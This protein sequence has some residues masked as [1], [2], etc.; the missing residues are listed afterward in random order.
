MTV[1]G[2]MEHGDLPASPGLAAGV[3]CSVLHQAPPVL[4]RKKALQLLGNPSSW[5]SEVGSNDEDWPCQL[6][7]KK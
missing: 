6:I 2:C 5:R 3:V 1:C 7:R 4:F